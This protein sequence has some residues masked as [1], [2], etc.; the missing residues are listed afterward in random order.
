MGDGGILLLHF[1]RVLMLGFGQELGQ[2]IKSR[3]VVAKTFKAFRR[4]YSW[5]WGTHAQSKQLSWFHPQL[6]AALSQGLVQVRSAKE[7]NARHRGSL[8]WP[9]A[10]AGLRTSEA[11]HGEAEQGDQSGP[12]PC[13][14]HVIWHLFEPACRKKKTTGF[15]HWACTHV[16]TCQVYLWPQISRTD[17]HSFR[18]ICEIA[19]GHPTQVCCNGNWFFSAC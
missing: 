8:L 15:E 16:I 14:N 6:S 18:Q 3:F 13:S 9:S 12:T 17:L 4:I 10:S 7:R 11:L 1:C 5:W 19:G 2:E